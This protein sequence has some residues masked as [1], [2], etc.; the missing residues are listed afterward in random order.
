MTVTS[1]AAAATTITTT[2]TTTTVIISHNLPL[3]HTAKNYSEYENQCLTKCVTVH[4][5]MCEKY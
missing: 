5:G 2:T 4:S 3:Y 1:T